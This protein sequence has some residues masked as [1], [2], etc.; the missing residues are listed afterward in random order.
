VTEEAKSKNQPMSP[1]G[2]GFVT[3]QWSLVVAAG[4]P[5]TP[6]ASQALEEL[7]GSYWYPLYAHIRRRG[8]DA[9]S[10]R[11]L[12]QGFFAEILSRNAFASAD[13]NRGRFRTFLLAA[14][15]NY[16][17][18][19]HRDSIAL[20]RGGGRE[21]VSWDAQDAEERYALEPQD[22]R[23]P[24]QEFDR[25]WALATLERVRHQLRTELSVAGKEQLFD[26]L[27]PYLAGESG[28][29]YADLAARLR[30]TTLALKVTVHRLRRRYRELLREEVART[31]AD[32]AD[33]D[34]ELRH[35]IEA[36]AD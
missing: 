25:R 20:K 31:L 10:A 5:Q 21:F 24:D 22:Q 33:A 6:G 36:L 7:C 28:T 14:L 27:R 12:T 35:L 23:S 19:Q 8:R 3:T 13:A 26:L 18:H 9:E 30:M 4:Q 2:P 32:P 16:L 17:H 29:P 34:A 1:T 11:D 15:D